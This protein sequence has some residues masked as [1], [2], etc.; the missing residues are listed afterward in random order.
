[1]DG[2]P[3]RAAAD[4]GFWTN[5]LRYTSDS[6]D[7]DFAATSSDEPLYVIWVACENRGFLPKSRRHHNGINDIRRFGHA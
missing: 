4:D 2:F 1:M 3:V 6:D 7:S 5:R